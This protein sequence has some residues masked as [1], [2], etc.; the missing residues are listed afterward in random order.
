VGK[1]CIVGRLGMDRISISMGSSLHTGGVVGSV[2][3]TATGP[4]ELVKPEAGTPS[5]IRGLPIV[6]YMSQREHGLEATAI[7]VFLTRRFPHGMLVCD[8]DQ[9]QKA[10]DLNGKRIGLGYYGNTDAT[11]VRGF[12]GE[13]CGVDLE[14]VTWV[15]SCDEQVKGVE[16]PGNVVPM[17]PEL[18]ARYTGVPGPEM[19][20]A[21]LAGEV[22]AGIYGRGELVTGAGQEGFGVARL[23]PLFSDIPTAEREWYAE[24]GIFPILGIVLLN[25]A[26]LAEHPDLPSK[27]VDVFSDA[28][29]QAIQRIEGGATLNKEELDDAALSGMPTVPLAK[30]PRAY[31]GRDP[32]PYGVEPNRKTL[33]T[34]VKYAYDQ[35]VLVSEPTVDELF[36]LPS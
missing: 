33:E 11:W 26:L 32:L 21:L 6:S 31:L 8:F 5:M 27:L 36:M 10:S 4:I 25:N 1:I 13:Y 29:E 14:S 24:T 3:E 34:I 12:L 35:H 15:T 7:P 19:D 30:S 20:A 23:A 17:H 22:V 2:I 28:K 16:L 9:V 18:G